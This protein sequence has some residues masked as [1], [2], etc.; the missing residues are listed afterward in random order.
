MSGCVTHSSPEPDPPPVEP[1]PPAV[2]ER[3]GLGPATGA[4]PRPRRQ[5]LAIAG[6]V[7][8]VYAYFYGGATW[9]ENARLDAIFAMVEPGTRDT[10]TF[11]IDRFIVAPTVN[12]GDWAHHGGHFYPNKAPGTTFLGVPFYSLLARLETSVGLDLQAATLS[13][14]NAYLIH[15]FV[16]VLWAAL[17]VAAF[18]LWVGDSLGAY[19]DRA[20]LLAWVLAFGTLTFPFS[21][22]LMGHVTALAWIVFALYFANDQA[23][24]WSE[25]RLLLAGLC[26]GLAVLTEYITAIPVCLLLALVLWRQRYRAW[27]FVAGGLPPLIL[28][29]VYHGVC[30]GNPLALATAFSNPA[31]LEGPASG[32]LL[33]HFT[34]GRLG[35]LLFGSYRGVFVYM[36]IL[37]LTL[38]GLLLWLEAEPRSQLAWFCAANLALYLVV[39]AGFGGWHG[40]ACAGPRYLITSLPFWVLP[41]RAV[42]R[43]RWLHWPAVL[44]ALI[45]VANMLVIATVSPTVPEEWEN[46]LFGCLYPMFAEGRFAPWYFPVKL[47]LELTP[48]QARL[49][50]FNLGG[51]LGWGNLASLALPVLLIAVALLLAVRGKGVRSIP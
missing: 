23:P 50:A 8:V 14:V 30:F 4:G 19:R 48:A 17:G 32:G 11:H 41:L 35:T 44:L 12:T 39:V 27:L 42:F 16:S 7:F 29:L 26:A 15:L 43:H 47:D 13:L 5:A 6:L 1:V 51:L 21:T 2:P 9:N 49:D 20:G 33:G 40:G 38:P 18:W 36:P 46:P 34:L 28:Y 37:V 45:S 24:A 31:V 25:R 22:V 10:G 3:S